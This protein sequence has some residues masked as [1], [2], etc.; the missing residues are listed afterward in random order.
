MHKVEKELCIIYPLI[1]GSK[2]ITFTIR[3]TKQRQYKLSKKTNAAHYKGT[4][5]LAVLESK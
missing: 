4:I 1:C 3:V 2:L 5:G